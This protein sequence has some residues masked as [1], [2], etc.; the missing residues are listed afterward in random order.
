V[1]CLDWL[2][3]RRPLIS[4]STDAFQKYRSATGGLLDSATGW[5]SITSAQY[6]NLKPLE[7]NIGGKSY[8]LTQN[9]QIWP[10]SLNTAIGG[11]SSAIYLVVGDSG[12]PSGSGLDF[13]LGYTFLYVS[14]LSYTVIAMFYICHL[15]VSA[16]TAYTTPKK[17]SVLPAL[18]T[19]TR[20]PTRTHSFRIIQFNLLR[21][22]IVYSIGGCA[23]SISMGID[24]ESQESPR[25]ESRFN[26]TV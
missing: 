24:Q 20:R 5:L 3:A 2:T 18:P 25:S 21:A 13:T 15:S 12:S 19:P 11:S 26:Y 9:G 7:F 23:T 4:V 16:T 14:S 10:R 1:T 6:D 22:H 8:D 17:E